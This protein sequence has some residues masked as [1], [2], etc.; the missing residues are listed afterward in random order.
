MRH[1][2]SRLDYADR[3][4]T[5]VGIPDPLIVGSAADVLEDDAAVLR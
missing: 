5:A 3:D 1:V 2:L 4:R